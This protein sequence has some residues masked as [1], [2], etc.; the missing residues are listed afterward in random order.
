MVSSPKENIIWWGEEKQGSRQIG[1][2]AMH[3]L[4]NPR[5]KM[6]SLRLGLPTGGMASPM[7]E[8]AQG[9]LMTTQ[10]SLVPVPSLW[11]ALSHWTKYPPDACRYE[12]HRRGRERQIPP[13]SAVP[14]P[15]LVLYWS[16]VVTTTPTC[17][18]LAKYRL[19]T[20]PPWFS[21]VKAGIIVK[22]L[23]RKL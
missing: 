8:R 9:S 11:A 7:A 16:D 6:V 5:C 2:S 13:E 18:A 19:Y 22:G 3:S 17:L 1:P 15:H 23:Y 12:T 21:W 10:H 20:F 14:A 4:E